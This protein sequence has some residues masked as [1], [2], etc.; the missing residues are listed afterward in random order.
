MDARTAQY[1]AK[2]AGILLIISLFAGAFGETIVPGKLFVASNAAETAHRMADSIGL[3]RASFAAYLI[4]AF[5]DLSLTAIFYLLLRPVS[6]PLSLIAACFGIF[7]TA[8]F[9]CGEIFYFVSALPVIDA[10]VARALTPDA[11]VPFTYLC[12]TLYGCVFNIFTAAY[13]IPVLLRGYLIL[14]SGYLPRLL[15]GIVMLAGAG[16]T[17]RSFVVILAPQYDSNLFVL[18]M[19]LAMV[20]MAF[21]FLMKGIDRTRW[22]QFDQARLT[23]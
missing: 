3:F 23:I 16:F 9:A 1:Y 20:S 5:C 22:E 8:T 14:R 2:M 10:N 19:L 15:G 4:E 13:G 21:W 18:P 11:G 12:L 7:S 17:L 6:R